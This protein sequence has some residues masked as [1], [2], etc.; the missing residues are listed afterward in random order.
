MDKG[1][2]PSAVLCIER[3]RQVVFLF[4]KQ[5]KDYGII[6]RDKTFLLFITAGILA[7]R[8]F[9]QLDLL[10]PVYTNDFVKNQQLFKWGN[11]LFMSMGSRPLEFC[12]P[13]TAF[14]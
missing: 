7:A 11:G 8:T 4:I 3:K 12:F 9:M 13:K 2:S 14:L 6:F 5:V 1:N 10:I